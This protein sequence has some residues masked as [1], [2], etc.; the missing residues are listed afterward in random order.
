LSKEPHP[1]LQGISQGEWIEITLK[2]NVYAQRYFSVHYGHKDVVLPRGYSASDIVQQIVLK[3]LEG[4]R[5]WDPDQHGDLLDYMVGQVRSLT[6][7]CLK[8]WPGKSEVPIEVDDAEGLT[9]EEII[10]FLAL[11]ESKEANVELLSNEVILLEKEVMIERN[12]LI[13]VILDASRNDPDLEAL[14]LTFLDSPDPRRGIIAKKMGKTPDEVTN[15]I[16]RLRRKVIELEKSR[17]K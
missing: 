15:L 6:N 7:H 3:V 8:S 14:V 16:K 5:K 12:A 1:A 9:A 4:A 17:Q 10:E 2:L 11:P 13:D